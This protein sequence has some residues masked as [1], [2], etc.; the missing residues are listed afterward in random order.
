M[1]KLGAKVAAAAVR[2]SD[3]SATATATRRVGSS[4]ATRATAPVSAAA[5]DA[6][7]CSTTQGFTPAMAVRPGGARRRRCRVAR[8]WRRNC[9]DGGAHVVVPG[10]AGCVAGR[11]AAR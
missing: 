7:T 9:L 4:S 5:S 6:F 1:C 10:K 2:T 8:V 11:A 3:E